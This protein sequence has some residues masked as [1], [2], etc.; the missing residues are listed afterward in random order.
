[1]SMKPPPSTP[2]YDY[3]KLPTLKELPKISKILGLPVSRAYPKFCV[4]WGCSEIYA[5]DTIVNTVLCSHCPNTLP[6]MNYERFSEAVNAANHARE[7]A[8]KRTSGEA[9]GGV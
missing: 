2:E 6:M 3:G 5:N 7:M 9:I 1:M 8:R 4:C